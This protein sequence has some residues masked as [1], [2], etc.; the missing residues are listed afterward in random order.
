MQ[1]I[2]LSATD[3]TNAYLKRLQR[4]ETLPDFTVVQAALQ[5]AG[6]GQRGARW[7]GEA[8]KN[9][10]FSVLKK[11][12][13]LPARTHFAL[14]IEV[15]LAVLRVLQSM[16]IPD[17]SIKWPNDILS[18][19]HKICGILIENQLKGDAISQS[20][21]GIGLNVNQLEFGDL[22]RASSLKKI[23]GRDYALDELLAALL[24]TL[25]RQL[26]RAAEAPFEA[27]LPDYYAHLFKKDKPA[28][29][30]RP[31]GEPFPAIIR[32]VEPDGKLRLE[33]ERGQYETFAFKELQL[34]Y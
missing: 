16:G 20:I 6:K 22:P 3:S 15:S 27:V 32:G 7:E 11:F 10:T 14:N 1:L 34:H 24:P 12:D 33:V 21:I 25:A 19:H 9:L 30:S 31:G 26:P 2:K 17:L 13:A 5:T 28:T 23:T 4:R 18:G 29:F 8:G